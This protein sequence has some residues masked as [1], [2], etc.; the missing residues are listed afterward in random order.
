MTP[1]VRAA[2]LVHDVGKYIARIARKVAP[3]G[4]VPATLVPLLVA[5]L[6]QSP[7]GGRPS[8]RFEAL[9]EQGDRRLEP[10]RTL[11]AELDRL[12]VLD[13]GR[14]VE[15]GTHDELVGQGGLYAALWAHQSGGFL[16]AGAEDEKGF[17]AAG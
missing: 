4:S 1:D 13:S 6:Y 9:A 7:G 5:D 3:D 10:V 8:E 17:V 2:H 12:V 14:I 16:D 11:F 15:T